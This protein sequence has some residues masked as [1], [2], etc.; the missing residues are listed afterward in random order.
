MNAFGVHGVD[1]ISGSERQD[2]KIPHPV[3]AGRGGL[4]VLDMP[5]Y[6]KASRESWG[7]EI[8]KYLVGRRQ[9]RRTFVLVDGEHG[10]K[11]SDMQMLEVL[12]DHGIA[13]Q[14]VLAKIDKVL[15]PR[16]RGSIRAL[17]QNLDDLPRIF[18]RAQQKISENTR[19]GLNASKDIITC[20]SEVDIPPGSGKKIGIDNLR[21]AILSAAGLDCDSSGNVRSIEFQMQEES[22]FEGTS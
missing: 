13:H 19:A 3:W 5:G 10:V 22:M 2:G 12:R 14:V 11:K 16:G 21:W 4:V 1:W 8:V 7:K 17:K 18:E 9:L 20:S 6:G 15:L